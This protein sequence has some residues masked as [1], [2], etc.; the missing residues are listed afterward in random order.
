MQ[1]IYRNGQTDFSVATVTGMAVLTHLSLICGA[2]PVTLAC[3]HRQSFR[4]KALNQ[5]TQKQCQVILSLSVSWPHSYLPTVPWHVDINRPC[6]FLTQT[7]DV[8]NPEQSTSRC[9]R[10]PQLWN[11]LAIVGDSLWVNEAIEVCPNMQTS[12][13]ASSYQQTVIFSTLYLCF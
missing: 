7:K 4:Q 3:T 8:W 2:L 1:C 5:M 11:H 9:W 12:T 13:T 10:N 6:A